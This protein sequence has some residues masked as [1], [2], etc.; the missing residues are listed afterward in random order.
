MAQNLIEDILDSEQ[1]E[2]FQ[3]AFSA[4]FYKD[5]PTGI[6]DDESAVTFHEGFTAGL[7]KR[8]TLLRT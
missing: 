3:E 6:L 4:G 8:R 7:A 1:A 2:V 5:R